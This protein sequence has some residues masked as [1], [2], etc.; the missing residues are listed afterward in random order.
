[1]NND[2]K[3]DMLKMM[4]KI[5]DLEQMIFNCG[6]KRRDDYKLINDRISEAFDAIKV[7]ERRE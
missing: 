7:L 6:A 1:M 2:I 4:D 5:D 3:S